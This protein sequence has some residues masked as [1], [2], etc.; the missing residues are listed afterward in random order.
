MKD[1]KGVIANDVKEFKCIKSRGVYV[2][3][4]LLRM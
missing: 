1:E 4:F 3:A 2:T